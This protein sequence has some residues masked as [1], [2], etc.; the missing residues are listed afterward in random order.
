MSGYKIPLSHV[1]GYNF[2]I[3]LRSLKIT[4]SPYSEA[5]LKKIMI[6]IKLVG[7]SMSFYF[8]K[9]LLSKCNV[10]RVVSIKQNINFK[11]QLP[12]M[13]ILL[14]FCIIGLIK[15]CSSEDLSAYKVWWSHVDWWKFYIHLRSLSVHFGMVEA[16][17]LKVMALRSPSVA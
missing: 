7:M 16:L 11:F 14:I 13:F 17:G 1:D 9:L 8:T 10:S 15:S 6:Q 5:P 12:A 2:C 3:H 4:P